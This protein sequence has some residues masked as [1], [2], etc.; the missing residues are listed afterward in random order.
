VAD[1]TGDEQLAIC[2]H[3]R[4]AVFNTENANLDT[5]ADPPEYLVIASDYLG[6]IEFETNKASLTV[7]DLETKWT[8][9]KSG[10][11]DC[12]GWSL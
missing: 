9:H 2:N 12:E 10:C 11:S 8:T 6:G 1:K 7:G 5:T 4:S 3:I